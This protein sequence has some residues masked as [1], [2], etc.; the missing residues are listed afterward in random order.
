MNEQTLYINLLKGAVIGTLPYANSLATS[1][2]D[3]IKNGKIVKEK[4][5]N[6]YPELIF[7]YGDM[8]DGEEE[9]ELENLLQNTDNQTLCERL[10]NVESQYEDYFIEMISERRKIVERIYQDVTNRSNIAINDDE[11][12]AIKK[13][14]SLNNAF[15]AGQIWKK[16]QRN[17][18]DAIKNLYTQT[19]QKVNHHIL[20]NSG[21]EEDSVDIWSETQAEFRRKLNHSPDDKGYYQWRPVSNNSEE[22]ASILTFFIGICRMRWRDILRMKNKIEAKEDDVI[23][24]FYQQEIGNDLDDFYEQEHLKNRIRTAIKQLLNPCQ[25]IVLGKWFGGEFGEGLTSKD[26]ALQLNYKAGTIDNL[27]RGCL[28]NLREILKS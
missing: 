16:I 10:S 2:A 20:Q 8:M 4:K 19:Y 6:I 27:H 1:Y 24:E 11:I 22:K 9:K 17:E 26:L 21:D 14:E 7:Y 5:A 12:L 13:S 18:N 15:D 3:L 23:S 25:E 28:E